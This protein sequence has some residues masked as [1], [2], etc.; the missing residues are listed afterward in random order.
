MENMGITVIIVVA[1]TLGYKIIM[2][3]VAKKVSV[4]NMDAAAKYIERTER[5]F[6]TMQI[7]KLLADLR[8]KRKKPR[9]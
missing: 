4:E 1:L 8:K 5:R 6:P 3:F 2:P 7:V 9:V